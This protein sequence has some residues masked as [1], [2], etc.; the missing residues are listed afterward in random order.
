VDGIVREQL[1]SAEA[2]VT[3]VQVAATVGQL[4]GTD[5]PVSIQTVY[6]ALAHLN[7][8]AR[9]GLV[10]PQWAPVHESG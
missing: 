1:R 5:P 8:V 3:A 9:E 2:P 7:R 6:T 10:T 4:C